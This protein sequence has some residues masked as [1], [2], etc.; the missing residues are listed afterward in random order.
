MP[1][2]MIRMASLDGSLRIQPR[3]PARKFDWT[4]KGQKGTWHFSMI[5]GRA[6]SKLGCPG[7]PVC[8]TKYSNMNVAGLIASI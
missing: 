7:V 8:S 2:E 4:E 6:A 1:E 5:N 3:V